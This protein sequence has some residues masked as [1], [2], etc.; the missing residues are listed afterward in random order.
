ME[1]LVAI[2]EAEAK[3]EAEAATSKAVVA[4][5]GD[6]VAPTALSQ[7]VDDPVISAKDMEASAGGVKHP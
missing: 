2:K 1:Q 3:A 6:A 5:V 4:K 7:P